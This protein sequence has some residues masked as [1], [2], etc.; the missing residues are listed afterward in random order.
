[1]ENPKYNGWISYT[2]SKN[3]RQ[4]DNINQGKWYFHKYD[5]RNNLTIT[6]DYKLNSTWKVASNFIFQTGSRIT[7]PTAIQH[8]NDFSLLNTIGENQQSINLGTF[9]SSR[10]NQTLPAYHRLD[11]GFTKNYKTSKRN[12]A[13]QLYVGVYNLYARANPYAAN[14]SSLYTDKKITVKQTANAL[15]TIIPS[16]AYSLKW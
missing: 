13:A 15:F 8:K 3:E 16:I 11:I 5:R 4:F 12:R 10:N 7:W 2:Y 14:W 1:K 6:L 9:Y